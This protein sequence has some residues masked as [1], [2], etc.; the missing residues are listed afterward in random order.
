[1]PFP[2]PT[3]TQ[4]KNTLDAEIEANFP[5]ADPKIQPGFFDTLSKAL[6]IVA[7]GIYI[8]QSFISKQPFAATAS[9]ENLDIIGSEIGID[10]LEAT[11]S[12]GDVD[13]TGVN[14]STISIGD[15]LTSGNG[16]TYL[17]TVGAVI[18]GGVATITVVSDSFGADTLQ[19]AG[20]KLTFV[21][22]PAGVDSQ[23]LVATGG[24]TGGT[25]RET[26]DSY[27]ARII[28]RKRNPI[29][30]G[31][32]TDYV[33]WAKETPGVAVTRAFV[34]PQEAGPGTV[35]VRFMTDDLTVNGIPSAADVISVFDYITSQMPI[36][37]VLTVFAPVAVLRDID[38]RVTPAT[39]E[40]IA[41]VTEELNDLFIRDA[42]PGGGLQ[43]SRIREAVSNAP[44]EQD[45]IVDDPTGD[46]AGGAA[47]DILVPGD[48]TIT[49]L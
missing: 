1:M 26:D 43:I 23:A 36:N 48:F 49:A 8:F 39:A 7:H 46:V 47:G 11:G 22:P 6:A 17:V 15:E 35:T 9:A 33:Q 24:L 40:V 3:P 31:T 44:G 20:V 34:F 2:I 37:V 21:S 28:E 18:A 32:A 30:C 27:R 25:D 10:R 19:L 42:A 13:C 14:A 5:S 29:Q 4:I 16:V 45:N 38:V 41:A 12:T